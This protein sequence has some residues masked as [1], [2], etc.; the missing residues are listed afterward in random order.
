MLNCYITVKL[1]Y[2]KKKLSL[3][4]KTFVDFTVFDK[5]KKVSL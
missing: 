5:T 3:M 2:D 1:Y 4:G